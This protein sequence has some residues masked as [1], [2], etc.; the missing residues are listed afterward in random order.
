MDDPLKTY[1]VKIFRSD[2]KDNSKTWYDSFTVPFEKGQS[3][4]GVMK[5]IYENLDPS[6]AFYDSCRIGKCTGCHIQ[7][8]HKTRLACTTITN[9]GD[10][11][12]EPLHGYPI[13]RDLVVDKTKETLMKR[14]KKSGM[15]A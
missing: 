4:L 8:N 13:V 7:V 12:L 5:Y 1:T 14:S 15:V 9:G 11:T 2:P 3:I 10:L 6:L